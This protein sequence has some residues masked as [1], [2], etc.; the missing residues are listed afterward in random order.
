MAALIAIRPALEADVEAIHAALLQLGDALG[1]RKKITGTA[2]D[3]RRAGFGPEPAFHGL[4]AEAEGVL[5]GL[6]LF[7]PIF[8]TWLGRGGVFV[9]DLYVAGEFRGRGVGEAL[10]RAVAA[11]SAE[12]GGAYLRLSVDVTNLRAQ[13]FYERVGITYREDEREHG[14]YGDAFQNLLRANK[15]ERP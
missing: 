12:R 2:E 13:T 9:Q 7:F 3:L 15:Q 4:I 11:W 1:Q 10:V 14:A 6:A 5:A 8:S